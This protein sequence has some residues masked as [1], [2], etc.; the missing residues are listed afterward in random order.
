MYKKKAEVKELL[1]R[2][3]SENIASTKVVV[4][5]ERGFGKY[6]KISH[7]H[8]VYAYMV[9]LKILEHMSEKGIFHI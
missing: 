4:T 7:P 8:L 3:Q 5:A 2:I 9:I 6:A 1:D